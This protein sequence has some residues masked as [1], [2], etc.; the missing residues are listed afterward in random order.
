M[1]NDWFAGAVVFHIIDGVLH[2]LLINVTTTNLKHAWQGT[3]VKFP[4][5]SG[6]DRPEENDP[7]VTCQREL[8]QETGLRVKPG[9]K[10]RV[11]FEVTG[12]DGHVK[13]FFLID[14]EDCRGDL[15]QEDIMDGEDRLSPPFWVDQYMADWLVYD[16]HQPALIRA[17]E[18]CTHLVRC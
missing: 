12:E 18:S 9:V 10:A 16:T 7:W 8:L 6:K 3:Q 2:L 11:I 15:R 5:G 4:G 14:F 13:V 17:I 1:G